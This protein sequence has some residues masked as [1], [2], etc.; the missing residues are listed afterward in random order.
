MKRPFILFIN[1]LIC[2]LS[3]VAQTD[4]T[5]PS[6]LSERLRSQVLVIGHRGGFDSNYPENSLALFDFTTSNGTNPMI[7][8]EIDIRKSA[9]GSLYL[10]H[11]PTVNRT[12]NGTGDIT[13]LEDTY[14]NG[15]QLID[16]KGQSTDQKI[17][18]FSDLL[19][20]YQNKPVVLMLDIKGPIIEEVLHLVQ[21]YKMEKQCIILT[22]TPENT[23]T[24]LKH[25]KNAMISTLI[26]SEKDFQA[27]AA[28]N[29]HFTRMAAYIRKDIDPQLLE[30]LIESKITILTDVLEIDKQ[31]FIPHE[32]TFYQDVVRKNKVAILV[33]DFPQFVS[34]HLQGQ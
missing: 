33:T 1:L 7:G 17:P 12:T 15:L 24:A 4:T 25:S 28:Y 13:Q 27:L 21:Q 23:Q 29:E 8:L 10:M 30:V 31:P 34:K 2:A 16:S 11:D 14:L 32:V 9:T 6:L 19:K 20:R 22:F 26:T 18:L 5:T 3:T